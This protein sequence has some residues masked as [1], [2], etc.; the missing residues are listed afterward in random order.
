[1]ERQEYT[2]IDISLLIKK[3][4]NKNNYKKILSPFLNTYPTADI[5]IVTKQENIRDAVYA[6]KAGA[7]NYVTSPI[8]NDEVKYVTEVIVEENLTL[9]EL[10]YLRLLA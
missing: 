7:S 2:F 10:D 6:V 8:N 5:V 3:S 4:T 9:L 1:M